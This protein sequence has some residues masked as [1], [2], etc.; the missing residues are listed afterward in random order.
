MNLLEVIMKNNRK[1]TL[2]KRYEVYRRL[3]YSSQTARALSFRSLDVSSLEISEKTGKLKRNK[4]TKVFIE[5]ERLTWENKNVVDKYVD[6]ISSIKNDTVYTRH[7]M[8]T[9]DKRY[10]GE[11]GKV[12]SII[13]NE[14][15]LNVNQAYY[16]F[17][18]MTQS[19]LNYEQAKK[20]L[21]SSKEFEMY[22]SHKK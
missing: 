2:K 9:H 15:K 8:L 13:K 10:K 21:L 20:E 22:R 7:G 3:G 12:I 4:Q 17:Y 5:N 16:L 18:Y 6:R 11:N 14:N 19:N 1:E